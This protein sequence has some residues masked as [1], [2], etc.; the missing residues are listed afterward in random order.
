ME[1]KE[2][3]AAELAIY[4]AVIAQQV[5][6]AWKRKECPY[7]T[8]WDMAEFGEKAAEIVD[9]HRK[10]FERD[11]PNVAAPPDGDE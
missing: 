11:F 4:G 7:V 6:K 8:E 10:T 1:P 9:L 2:Y 3:T 5:A